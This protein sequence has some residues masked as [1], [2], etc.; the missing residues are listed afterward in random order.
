MTSAIASAMAGDWAAL[1]DEGSPI[2]GSTL[3]FVP[4]RVLD[5]GDMLYPGATALGCTLCESLGDL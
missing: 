1:R 2:P 3:P 5:L 4:A